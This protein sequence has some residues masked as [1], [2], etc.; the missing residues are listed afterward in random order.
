MVLCGCDEVKS[1]E[2]GV[3]PGLPTWLLG[4]ITRGLIHDRREAVKVATDREE[5]ER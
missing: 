2:T 1:L 4:P 5:K 3:C